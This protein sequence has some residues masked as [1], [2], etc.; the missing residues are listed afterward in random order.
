[1]RFVVCLVLIFAICGSST[2]APAV[3]S[4][5]GCEHAKGT[6]EARIIGSS[7]SCPFIIAGDVFDENLTHIGTTS[8]CLMS[9]ENKG[10]VLPAALTHDYSI[11]DLNF[12]TVDQGVLTLIAPNLFRFE[13]RLTIVE[14][15]SGFL[16]AHGTVDVDSGE[17]LLDFNGQICV[18]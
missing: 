14:G 6:V 10:N 15:A 1:M 9:A 2:I 4:A 13:N 16:R 18:E 11:G 7:A 17:I 12:S 8:A 5:S 3:E